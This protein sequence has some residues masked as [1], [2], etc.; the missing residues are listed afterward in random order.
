MFAVPTERLACFYC[1]KEKFLYFSSLIS[2]F[3]KHDN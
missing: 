1:V 2:A 3:L